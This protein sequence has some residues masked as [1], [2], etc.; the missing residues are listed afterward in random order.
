[1]GSI[2]VVLYCGYALCVPPLLWLTEGVLVGW[3]LTH[4]YYRHA[5]AKA[6]LRGVKDRPAID[7]ALDEYHK[8]HG[9]RRD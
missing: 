5:R 8:R 7:V 9:L 6:W 4:R 1:M 2:I 3:L